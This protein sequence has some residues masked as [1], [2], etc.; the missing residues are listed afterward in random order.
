MISLL[1]LDYYIQDENIKQAKQ[2]AHGTSILSHFCPYF[3]GLPTTDCIVPASSRATRPS[4]ATLP[5]PHRARPRPLG[6]LNLRITRP[7]G[8]VPLPP[9][10]RCTGPPPCRPTRSS[11]ISVHTQ[12]M[13]SGRSRLHAHLHCAVPGDLSKNASL[14]AGLPDAS[15]EMASTPGNSAIAH[16]HSASRPPRASRAPP[17][18]SSQQKGAVMW[19]SKVARCAG[20][21]SLLTC[22]K[23]PPS[24][25]GPWKRDCS[26]RKPAWGSGDS[27]K[28][29]AKSFRRCQVRAR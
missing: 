11:S 17:G 19:A 18:R 25:R 26:P 9:R 24:P 2:D 7:A 13:G 12:A 29:R 27:A 23:K 3:L 21:S 15:E 4:A 10:L 22:A 5:Q 6:R 1:V 28:S 16:A 20:S 14:T 8:A